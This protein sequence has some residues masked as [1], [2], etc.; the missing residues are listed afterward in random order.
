MRILSAIGAAAAIAATVSAGPVASQEALSI[1]R[2]VQSGPQAQA[3][4][5]A[6]SR[7]G[8]HQH[9]RRR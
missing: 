8:P 5:T 2:T 7:G 1:Y 6:I 3:L 4:A 9:A